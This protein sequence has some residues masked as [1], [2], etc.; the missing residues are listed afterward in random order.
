ML[1]P[2]ETLKAAISG[3]A[4]TA[5]GFLWQDLF[6]AMISVSSGPLDPDAENTLLRILRFDGR[7]PL[8]ASS[9]MP[10][11]MMPVEMLK[12][13]ALQALG[14]CTGPTYLR[15]MERIQATAASPALAS[16][17]KAV[18]HQARLAT[19]RDTEWENIDEVFEEFQIETDAQPSRMV[20]TVI[21]HMVARDRGLTYLTDQR[22]R[23]PSVPEMAL[24]S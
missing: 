14:R 3:S 5:G 9:D 4:P 20:P 6:A 21:R 2:L 15:L 1:T 19:P 24:A 22:I 17:A 18:I 11:S 10:H 8:S 12:S 23:M 7:M 16:T 13:L